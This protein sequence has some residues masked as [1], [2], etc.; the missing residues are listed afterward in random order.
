[1]SILTLTYSR[2]GF[3]DIIQ[4]FELYNLE[5]GTIDY[6]GKAAVT[7]NVR[8]SQIAKFAVR[9]FEKA[10]EHSVQIHKL[11]ELY[12]DFSYTIIF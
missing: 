10:T 3:N 4:S 2:D 12:S 7:L 6:Q 9:S 1:M 8:G 11:I 5:S